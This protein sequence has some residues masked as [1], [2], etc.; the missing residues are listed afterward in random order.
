M[1]FQ[2][3]KVMETYQHI[4]NTSAVD[5]TTMKI[6]KEFTGLTKPLM[7]SMCRKSAY[8]E[9]AAVAK[10][11]LS[12]LQSVKYDFAD[13]GKANISINC[14]NCENNGRPAGVFNLGNDL[15]KRYNSWACTSEYT[16]NGMFSIDI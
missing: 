4:I 13:G 14:Q 1:N 5:N 15:A 10:N 3:S 11:K 16:C 8:G 2:V 12:I 6:K 7:A 9:A